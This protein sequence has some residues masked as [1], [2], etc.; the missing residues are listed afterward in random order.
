MLIWGI[1]GVVGRSSIQQSLIT[2]DVLKVE[3]FIKN[4]RHQATAVAIVTLC[5]LFTMYISCLDAISSHCDDTNDFP[6][7][8]VITIKTVAF[9]HT[10]SFL[11]LFYL[12]SLVVLS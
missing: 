9:T 4:D 1:W 7:Y 11:V 12:F 8:K 5:S 3:A 6:G 10:P 2:A